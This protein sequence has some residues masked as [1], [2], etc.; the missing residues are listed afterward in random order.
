MVTKVE[1]GR[2]SDKDVNSIGNCYI[3][4]NF[5]RL[6]TVVDTEY[7]RHTAVLDECMWSRGILSAVDKS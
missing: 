7:I 3:L 5:M 2:Y 6:L 4:L 1:E